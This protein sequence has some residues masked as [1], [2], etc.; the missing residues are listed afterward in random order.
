MPA[1]H[2]EEGAVDCSQSYARREL[3]GGPV[4]QGRLRG[5]RL[6]D[7]FRVQNRQN[8]CSA[9]GELRLMTKNSVTVNACV[10]YPVHLMS[11]RYRNR[12]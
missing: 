1:G 4:L 6:A 5:G 3:G 9:L 12:R 2:H 8:P 11:S 10:Y 7:L